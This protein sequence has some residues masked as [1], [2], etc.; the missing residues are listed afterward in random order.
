MHVTVLAGGYGGARF[1]AGLRRAEPE[2]KI[3]VI[4]N[5]A[6]DLIAFGL[7]ISP[8]LDTIMYTLGR[9]LD[10]DRGWGRSD[11]GWRAIEELRAYGVEP[12]WFGL[13]DRDLATHLVR[14]QMLN[15][16]YPLHLVTEALCRRWQPGVDLLPMTNDRVETHVLVD[17]PSGRQAMHF[18]QWWIQHH[19]KLPAHGFVQIGIEE[20]TPAPGVIEALTSADVI[21][22]AP[23]NPV[24][25]IGPILAVPRLRQ[26]VRQSSAAVVGVSPIIGG[27]PVRGMADACLTAIGVP[28]SP[29]GVA[30]HYGARASEGLL[31]GWLL[32]SSDAEQVDALNSSGITCRAVPLWLDPADAAAQVAADALHLAEATRS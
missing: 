29:A 7:N 2:A 16:G 32:D 11:E 31:D 30:Q 12:G 9:G 8:D 5:T 3:T 27:G 18:Q 19:A 22:L 6:D 28:V 13:G 14:T 1:V 4:G 24:V 10:T 15:G 20:A 21:V 26:Q 23:S 25:S 17:Q